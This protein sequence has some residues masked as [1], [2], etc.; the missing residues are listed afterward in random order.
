MLKNKSREE[1]FNIIFTTFPFKIRIIVKPQIDR[2]TFKRV[3]IK[4]GRTH[5][6]S[7]DVIGEPV[8]TLHWSWRDNIPLTSGDRIKIEN[9]DYHTDFIISNV[10]RKDSGMY[11]LKAENRN[12]TDTETVELLVLGKPTSPKGP[13]AVSDVTA[14]GCKLQWKKP[15]DDGG[16]PIKEYVVEKMDTATGKW[17][18]VGRS[19]GEKEPPSFDVTGLNPGSEYM[20]RVSAVN[21]EGES[22]PLTTLVGVVAKDPY[23]EPN[24]PGTPEVTDYDNQSVSIKWTAPSND[25]GAPIEKYI[26]EKKDK[27][28]PDWEKAI[29]VPG[30][31]L[32]ATVAGLQEYGEYQFRVVAVNKAG[33]SPPSDA[34]KMQIVKYKKCKYIVLSHTIPFNCSVFSFFI[35][36]FFIL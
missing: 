35:N 16:V 24:K 28:K 19:P 11:T 14:T 30:D 13:L 21:E 34:S 20:F 33:P 4:T 32:E 7:V 6:W 5:K 29:E 9:V 27:N 8:P 31:Q 23:D 2:S 22:E 17:I 26:I 3:T 10:V 18:R 25:G 15:D 36:I 12:G 1:K